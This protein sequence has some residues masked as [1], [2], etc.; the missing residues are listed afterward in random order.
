M[1]HLWT[2]EVPG[3]GAPVAEPKRLTDGDKFSVGEFS[4]SPDGTRIAFS[5]QRD[6]DLISSETADLYVVMLSD[7]V[8]KKI[9]S[10]PGPDTNPKWSPD[11]KKIA[12]ISDLYPARACSQFSSPRRRSASPRTGPLF[13][14]KSGRH[15][16]AR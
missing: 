3:G 11:G 1:M 10:T 15:L 14:K 13:P 5:A 4:W 8:V 6:A 7:G 12:T 9:V 2:M 16:S